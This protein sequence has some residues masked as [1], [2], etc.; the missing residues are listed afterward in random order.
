MNAPRQPWRNKKPPPSLAGASVTDETADQPAD[1][2]DAGAIG[3]A[4]DEDA[5]AIGAADDEAGAIGAASEDDAAADE[6]AG[7]I[8]AAS[9]EDA[10]ADDDAGAAEELTTTEL[11]AVLTVV[12]LPPRL[13]IQMRPMI[14]ITATIMIIQVLRF[15]GLTLRLRKVT[16][17]NDD[18]SCLTLGRFP[19]QQ[20]VLSSVI[21]GAKLRRLFA[22]V[23]N[24]HAA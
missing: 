5:G 9:D 6:D 15:M 16:G 19:A 8:G 13:K 4:S 1:E 3:V 18:R 14:T 20:P 21:G 10:A 12:V 7:A 23:V 2:D 22:I 11:D 17:K 24:G